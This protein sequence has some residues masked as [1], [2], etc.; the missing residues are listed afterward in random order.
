MPAA[1]NSTESN[2]VEA[3]FMQ[4]VQI[5]YQ[6]LAT[7][8]TD[9]PNAEQKAVGAFRKGLG[10]AR[11]ARD[12]ALQAVAAEPMAAVAEAVAVTRDTAKPR[13][14]KRGRKKES[15]PSR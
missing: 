1:S 7:N 11:R 12:L 13:K 6:T 14:A 2:A 10:T 15:Q 3:A 9:S 5:L 8:L 4:R